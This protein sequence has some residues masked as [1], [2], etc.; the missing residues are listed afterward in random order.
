MTIFTGLPSSP[1]SIFHLSNIIF[2]IFSSRIMSLNFDDRFHFG[3]FVPKKK[4]KKGK[5]IASLLTNGVMM[6]IDLSKYL[7]N[8]P[9]IYQHLP[10]QLYTLEYV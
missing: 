6:V 2:E 10:L 9:Y 8:L 3:P 5:V 7:P 1:L 4:K